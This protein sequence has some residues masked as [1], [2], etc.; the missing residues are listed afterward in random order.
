[1]TSLQW[2]DVTEPRALYCGS[3]SEPYYSRLASCLQNMLNLV[4]MSPQHVTGRFLP[5]MIP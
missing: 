2:Y 3:C 1:M 5:A 4:K